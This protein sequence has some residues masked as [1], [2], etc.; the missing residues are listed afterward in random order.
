MPESTGEWG[1]EAIAFDGLEAKKITVVA[2]PSLSGK[3]LV[4]ASYDDQA[5]FDAMSVVEGR[6]LA[7]KGRGGGSSFSSVS[8]GGISVSGRGV[9]VVNG[10]VFRGNNVSIV[11]GRTFVDGVEVS[12]DGGQPKKV[13][14][15][16][17]VRAPVGFP[18]R[19]VGVGGT[20]FVVDTD[21]GKLKAEL[22][23]QCGLRAGH[24]AS[25]AVECSGQVEAVFDR[26]TGDKASFEVSGQCR[27]GVGALEVS[28]VDID[29]SGQS[30]VIVK[31]GAVATLK[32]DVCGQSGVDVRATAETA[33][34][35]ASGMSNIFVEEVTGSVDEDTSGLSRINVSRRPSSG[36]K[37]GGGWW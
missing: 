32:V 23:G 30:K 15:S 13:T 20:E 31:S 35:E 36:S 33:V 1:C 17:E 27:V 18:V 4:R 22:D 7:F 11:N 14:L 8:I 9:N 3:V 25:P 10:R 16:L 2:D 19:V 29:V 28:T 5:E 24:V 12:G 6:E 21:G 34:L 37:P 26:V